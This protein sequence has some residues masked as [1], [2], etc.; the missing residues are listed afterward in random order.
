MCVCVCVREQNRVAV[1]FQFYSVRSD[2]FY[3]A[4]IFVYLTPRTVFICIV[5]ILIYIMFVVSSECNLF[6]YS[7]ICL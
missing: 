2:L 7:Y 5:I 4:N 1:E 3:T 6:F